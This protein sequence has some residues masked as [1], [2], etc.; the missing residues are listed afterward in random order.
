MKPKPVIIIPARMQSERLPDKPLMDIAGTSLLLRTYHRALE[1]GIEHIFIAASDSPIVAYCY[2]HD[3]PY[4][5]T[6]ECATGTHRCALALD[7]IEH[8]HNTVFD[9]V[10]NWQVD[11]PFVRL[12]DVN[13]LIKVARLNDYIMTLAAPMNE[14]E[15]DDPN[16]VKVVGPLAAN[17]QNEMCSCIWF[18]RASMA[19]AY[20]HCGIYAYPKWAL[21]NVN[22]LKATALS[23]AE[24]LEQLPWIEGGHEIGAIILDK[25]P[26]SI[27]TKSDAM[28]AEK[29]YAKTSDGSGGDDSEDG[30]GA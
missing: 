13:K 29:R 6:K 3:M 9:V 28:E 5:I 2:G 1:T 16:C 24:G 21:Q 11:E 22:L 20:G 8:E 10:I 15:L 25:M 17:R 23:R 30:G 7:A 27:N 14:K 12:E 26:L 18:S 4:I 19:G